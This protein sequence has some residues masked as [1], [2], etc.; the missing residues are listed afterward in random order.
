M[1]CDR[2]GFPCSSGIMQASMQA[3]YVYESQLSVREDRHN[4]FK[5]H[6]NIAEKDVP[7]WCKIPN[8]TRSSQTGAS[9]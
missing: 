3:Y 1:S 6:K 7:P 5:G 4:E 8:S 9:K 2:R